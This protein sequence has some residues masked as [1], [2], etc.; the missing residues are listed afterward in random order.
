MH[1]DNLL[2]KTRA[3]KRRPLPYE[4]KRYANTRSPRKDKGAPNNE[5]TLQA[6]GLHEIWRFLML[7]SLEDTVIFKYSVVEAS[8]FFQ[9]SPRK[10]GFIPSQNIL[11]RHVICKS[12][13]LP[14]PDPPGHWRTFSISPRECV[15]PL[16]PTNERRRIANLTAGLQLFGFFTGRRHRALVFIH[17]QQLRFHFL[18]TDEHLLQILKVIP[19]ASFIPACCQRVGGQI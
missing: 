17:L 9:L 12:G 7:P 4:H 13:I 5:R 2:H 6:D 16:P 8:Y 3:Q 18:A 11:R 1:H 10:Q 19:E 15:F 14:P